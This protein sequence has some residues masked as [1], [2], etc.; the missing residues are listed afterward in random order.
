MNNSIT[1]TH[2]Y[3]TLADLH[4]ATV[5][6][7]E[8]CSLELKGYLLSGNP[9]TGKTTQALL[10]ARDYWS[11]LVNKQYY[12]EP[13]MITGLRLEDLIE[14][15]FNFDVS[16]KS[17]AEKALQEIKETPF[18]IIDDFNTSLIVKFRKEQFDRVIWDIIDYR[19]LHQLT[20]IISTN[21]SIPNLF[22]N[23]EP[24]T[25]SR[26]K[27]LCEIVVL[28]G[29]DKREKEAGFTNAPEPTKLEYYSTD[30]REQDTSQW[31][32]SRLEK[33]SIGLDF[34]KARMERRRKQKGEI[35]D[36]T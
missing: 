7:S 26:L 36:K 10:L 30:W 3:S 15:R 11:G 18:L 19:L 4:R 6:S 34:L 9:G 35:I 32:P 28:E 23:L 5:A 27:A 8:H 12:N 20:T 24:R 21:D 1:S 16:I 13:V 14:S 31:S 17:K 25:L 33:A 22:N 2:F 29:T